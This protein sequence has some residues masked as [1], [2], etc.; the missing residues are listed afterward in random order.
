MIKNYYALSLISELYN[1]IY[2][3]KWFITLN[4]QRAYNLIRM[5]KEEK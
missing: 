3:A 2:K 4:L 1:R 5:K